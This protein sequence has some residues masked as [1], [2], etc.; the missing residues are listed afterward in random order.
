M[1]IHVFLSKLDDPKILQA[2]Q[3][4]EARSSGEIR[5]F[6]SAKKV[7]DPVAVA[8]AH[9]VRLGMEK[10]RE[11]NGVLIYFA[12]RSRKFA[13]VGDV[14]VHALCG[15]GLWQ[16]V[17]AAMASHLKQE[18]YTQALLA[19]IER[20]GGVLASHFPRQPNDKNELPD[21]IAGD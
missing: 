10:T 6:V 11:R 21:A 8:K 16:E 17:A 12:P 5:V 7:T 1:K 15:D 2:I 3:Q 14:G 13:V 4:A 19:A 9:F 18:E 20:V